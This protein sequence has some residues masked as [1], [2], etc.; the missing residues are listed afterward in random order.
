MIKLSRK[1]LILFLSV[2]IVSCAPSYSL[3]KPGTVDY[4]GL[5]LHTNQ[6]W[7]LA[8]SQLS[9][10]SR[11]ESVT[12][13][14]DGQL[15]DRILIIPAVPDGEPIFKSTSKS[16]AL[17]VFRADMAAKDIE[18]LTESSI[19]KLFGEG[20][21]VVETSKLRPHRFGGNRGFLFDVE[22]AVN[23]GPDYGGVAG[24][25]IHVD[26]LYMMIYLG[27][28]PYYFNRHKDEALAIIRGAS[29]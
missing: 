24:A 1:T 20:E 19:M 16:Q 26:N 7:N 25:F 15:L 21:V 11:R 9:P 12:W 8:P 23:D 22:M 5:K 4:S 29:L 17:P 13:T 6:A 10:M 2:F 27:A 28:K 14:Q 3:V 18:E